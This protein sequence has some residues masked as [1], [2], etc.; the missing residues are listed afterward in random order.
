MALE[1]LIV[2]GRQ[3]NRFLIYEIEN[4]VLAVRLLA[5][6]NTC[7]LCNT[8]CNLEIFPMA[9]IQ[10]SSHSCRQKEETESSKDKL[11]L[12]DIC[13]LNLQMPSQKG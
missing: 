9:K 1:N 12:F 3:N 11:Q 8:L 2:K 4:L 7:N 13:L 5:S 10:V 6:N